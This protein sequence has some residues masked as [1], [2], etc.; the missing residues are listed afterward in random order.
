[1]SVIILGSNDIATAEY[2]KVLGLN[3]STLVTDIAH[4]YLIGIKITCRNFIFT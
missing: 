3:S 2:Y 4:R 1:M